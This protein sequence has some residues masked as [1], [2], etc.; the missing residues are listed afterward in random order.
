MTARSDSSSP[1][2]RQ[3]IPD[4]IDRQLPNW[5]RTHKSAYLLYGIGDA[6]CEWSF[7]SW[8]HAI[9]L[10]T[11]LDK[12]M[13]EMCRDPEGVEGLD[14]GW[15]ENWRKRRLNFTQK[16][17]DGAGEPSWAAPDH[18]RLPDSYFDDRPGHGRLPALVTSRR[19]PSSP[20]A[21]ELSGSPL[22]T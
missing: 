16:T 13:V 1:L 6:T 20:V 19:H 8:E 7:V 22:T 2:S 5:I 4:V 3:I 18:L 14:E 10:F 21:V 12:I 17:R 15:V 9:E 11:H